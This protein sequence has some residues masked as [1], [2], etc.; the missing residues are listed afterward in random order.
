VIL[1]FIFSL[2]NCQRLG[3]QKGKSTVEGLHKIVQSTFETWINESMAITN[4]NS[5]VLGTDHRLYHE[6]F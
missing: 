5:A 3:H 6:F 2:M 1:V 4:S